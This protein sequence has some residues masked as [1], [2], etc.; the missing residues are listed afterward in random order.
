MPVE[1]DIGDFAIKFKSENL[2]YRFQDLTKGLLSRGWKTPDTYGGGFGSQED[3]PAVYMFLL[4]ERESYELSRPA[5]V[6]MSTR[7]SQ[8]WTGHPILRDLE[9]VEH[10]VQRWFL[11]TPA[12]NL[13]AVESDL[14][15][16]LDP[17]WNIAGRQRGFTS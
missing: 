4:V 1:D 10:W 2:T 3:F 15:R 6:G 17:P 14:I 12:E 13:R 9:R 5:Y 11:K 8:R 16:Q 7:L